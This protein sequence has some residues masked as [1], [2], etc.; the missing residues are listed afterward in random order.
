M[1]CDGV[2]DCAVSFKHDGMTIE[3]CGTRTVEP[4]YHQFVVV[5]KARTSASFKGLTV[6]A[7]CFSVNGIRRPSNYVIVNLKTMRRTNSGIQSMIAD[8]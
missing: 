4:W 5:I 7:R 3:S 8:E 1:A 6:V 2:T